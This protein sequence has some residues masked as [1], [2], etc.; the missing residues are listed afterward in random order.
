MQVVP[1]VTDCIQE[2]I[3]EVAKMPVDGSSIEPDVAAHLRDAYAAEKVMFPWQEGDVMLLD[4]MSVAHARE[5]YVGD[6][7]V[8]VAM[9]DA[10]D[11]RA[12]SLE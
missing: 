2:W 11:E 10:I 8:V 3:S 5:P 12:C 9:T 4:N 7:L 1:H 6:R